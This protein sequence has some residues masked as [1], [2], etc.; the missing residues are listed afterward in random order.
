MKKTILLLLVL[1]IFLYLTAQEFEISK[2]SEIAYA[3]EFRSSGAVQIIDNHLFFLN[4][5]GL[6]IY[7]INEGGSLTKLSVVT[8]PD[9]S[10]MVIYEQNC[11]IST[12][13]YA[14]E[15]YHGKV[16]RI[17]ISN[18][19]NPEIIDQIE[20]ANY[21]GYIRLKILDNNLVVQTSDYWN[22][23]YK[24]YSLPEMEYLGQA[25]EDYY[26][27]KVNDSLMVHQDENILYTKHY[28][29]HGNFELIGTT[30]VSAYSDDGSYYEHFKIINDT[31]LAAVNAKNVTFWDISD[32]TNWQYLSRYTL[33]VNIHMY[34]N[35]QYEIIDGNVILFTTDFIRLLDISDITNPVLV[36]TIEGITV[37]YGQACDN[38]GNNLYVSSSNFGIQH[39]GIENN[40]MEHSG[41]YYDHIRF[42]LG[43]MYQDK[44]IVGTVT[45]GYYLF[46]VENPL[47]PIDQGDWFNDKCY[48][49]VHKAG[50]W[51][52]LKDYEEYTIDIYN[53]TDPENPELINTLPLD[54]YGFSA[55]YCSIDETDPF[56]FYLCNQQTNKLWKFDIS[57]QG[58]PVELFGFDLPST[59][60]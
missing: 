11:Y 56:S 33:P 60:K 50:G 27:N 38:Y 42:C 43:D 23:F 58:E 24:S 1:N 9:P 19:S 34:G 3:Q 49:M 6:E 25:V 45:C 16:Y 5:N 35:K 17:D 41:I 4:L 36:D 55:T 40:T 14:V 7:G 53:I 30:D 26:Y 22:I 46:D 44:I 31:L 51:I 57:E 21:E 13:G 29:Q 37:I 15:G 28:I 52:I 8:I 54:E 48:Q 20:Y 12:R 39:Y 18:T 59:P 2:I 32:A 10:S 47:A